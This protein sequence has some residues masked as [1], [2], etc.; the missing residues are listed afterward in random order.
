MPEK[1]LRRYTAEE[2]ERLRNLITPA[3]GGET[4]SDIEWEHTL[5]LINH[6]QITERRR[7]EKDKGFAAE[8]TEAALKTLRRLLK[9]AGEDPRTH[10][11]TH[12]LKEQKGLARE[13]E[14]AQSQPK[15]VYEVLPA[16]PQVPALQAE[17]TMKALPAPIYTSR[18]IAVT[19]QRNNADSMVLDRRS[20]LQLAGVTLGSL[21][22][23]RA[24]WEL[25]PLVETAHA[26]VLKE[27]RIECETVL[28]A[29]LD[30]S[31]IKAHEAELPAALD[32]CAQ[33][34]VYADQENM[35]FSWNTLKHTVLAAPLLTG[36]VVAFS[37]G[38]TL[39][40]ASVATVVDKVKRTR[41]VPDKISPSF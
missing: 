4:V 5:G 27:N 31:I 38:I 39:A 40:W 8:D 21:A 16:A 28:R 19:P 33:E 36:A 11:L 20:F 30:E 26:D 18:V 14:V 35:R 34:K 9:E 17:P 41:Q 3:Q 23:A 32:T 10:S 6:A 12:F 24:G 29:N 2:L 37:T 25:Q 15:V 1:S 13:R 22:I 7:A